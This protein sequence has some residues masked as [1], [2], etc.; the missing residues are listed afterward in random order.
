MKNPTVAND[1]TFGS[2]GNWNSYGKLEVIFI[3]HNL[4]KSVPIV[5]SLKQCYMESFASR[6]DVGVVAVITNEGNAGS[7]SKKTRI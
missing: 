6:L 2:Y 5:Y 1:E 3:I 4:I 7:E